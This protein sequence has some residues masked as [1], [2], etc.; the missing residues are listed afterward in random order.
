M[1]PLRDGRVELVPQAVIQHEPRRNL[2]CVLRVEVHVVARDC[3]H[4][5]LIALWELRRRHCNAV[6]KCAALEERAQR[7][8]QLLA[9]SD[10]VRSA[11][12]CDRTRRE[13]CAAAEYVLPVGI[14]SEICRVAVRPKLTAEL[15]RMLPSRP[16]E[17]LLPHEEIAQ[18][19]GHRSAGCVERFVQSV[20]E[21]D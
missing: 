11:C 12:R 13:S 10:V 15:E 14:G 19:C 9:G 8:G 3:R 1:R 2:P 21:Y 18:R 16:R 20:A 17:I 6:R 5:D 4:A 7:V